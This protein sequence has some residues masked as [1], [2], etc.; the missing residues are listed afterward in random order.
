M[1]GFQQ[2]LLVAAALA[3]AVAVKNAH[4]CSCLFGRSLCDKFEDAGIV[5]RGTVTT[6]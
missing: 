4:A 6:R 5:L 3:S 2:R 1:M